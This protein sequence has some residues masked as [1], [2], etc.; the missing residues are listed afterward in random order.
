MLTAQVERYILL[1]QKL[2]YKL[3]EQ[4][5]GLRAFA[6]FAANRGDL[7][8]VASTAVDWAME[9]HSTHARYTRLR[10]VIYLAR[11]LHAEDPSHEVPFN[12]FRACVRRRLPYIYSSEE[13]KQL[14]GAARRLRQTYPL[15]RRV[16]ETLLGLCGNRAPYFGGAQPQTSR[17]P[18]RWRAADP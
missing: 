17:R 16:Y 11:F 3:R 6:R 18:S 1:R 14:I 7:H 5:I 2:G 13:I 8:I 15:R 4:G 9:S 12:H 10:N